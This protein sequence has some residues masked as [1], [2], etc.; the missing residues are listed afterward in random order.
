M[1]RRASHGEPTLLS[2]NTLSDPSAP[3]LAPVAGTDASMDR[4]EA[5][6]KA[7]KLQAQATHDALERMKRTDEGAPHTAATWESPALPSADLAIW[8]AAILLILM[9]L[10]WGVR[11]VRQWQ[12][13][14]PDPA[15]PVT[16]IPEPDPFYGD[17][18]P[19]PVLEGDDPDPWIPPKDP[20]QVF[21]LEAAASEVARVRK[22]LAERRRARALQREEDARKLQELALMAHAVPH[23]PLGIVPWQADEPVGTVDVSLDVPAEELIHS[24]P[25]P[26]PEVDDSLHHIVERDYAVTLALAQESEAVDL[27]SEARDL[28]N[29]VLQSSNP[30]LKAQAHALLARLDQLESEKALESR[31]WGYTV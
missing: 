2:S 7:L 21:D 17:S 15:G 25:A 16:E 8:G 29:E 9:V 18:V 23:P 4:V 19:P 14:T 10:V 30:A 22:T 28:A 27:W 6:L 3:T 5:E 1:H 13:A 24:A 12:T 26:L 20:D 11:R 31:L